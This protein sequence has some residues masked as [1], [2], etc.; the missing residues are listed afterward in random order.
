VARL[1]KFKTSVG[2]FYILLQYGKWHAVFD[3]ES[4]G[5]YATPQQA[6]DDLAGGH[7]FSISG[8]HDTAV[9]G[10]PP[11]LGEWDKLK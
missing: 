2:D 8:G 1:Y 9:L 7:T 3:G 11:D 4:V 6:A 5:A 10:I